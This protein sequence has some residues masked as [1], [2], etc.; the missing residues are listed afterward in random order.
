MNQDELNKSADEKLAALDTAG[1]V[2]EFTVDEA[3]LIGAFEEDA[4]SFEVAIEAAN[5]ERSL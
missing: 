2:V 3:A 5:D 1:V 4:I